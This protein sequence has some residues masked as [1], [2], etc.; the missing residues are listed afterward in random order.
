MIRIF[1][2][3]DAFRRARDDFEDWLMAMAEDGGDRTRQ[4][5]AGLWRLDK[6]NYPQYKDWVDRYPHWFALSTAVKQMVGEPRDQWVMQHFPG[7]QEIMQHAH[8]DNGTVVYYPDDHECKLTWS[9]LE[10]DEPMPLDIK[11]GDLVVMSGRTLH[12]VQPNDTKETRVS[13]V[14]IYG[15]HQATEE[16]VA[17]LSRPQVP[18]PKEVT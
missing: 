12:G 7:G 8:N 2:T 4:T 6:I 5:K 9:E 1:H 18:F 17:S 10:G 13:F 14:Y 15:G 3:G 11:A 16:G